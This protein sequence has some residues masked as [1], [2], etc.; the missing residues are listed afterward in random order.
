[1]EPI[2]TPETEV[3]FTRQFND[4]FEAARIPEKKLNKAITEIIG[5][6]CDFLGH[7]FHKKRIGSSGVGKRG[8]F[9]GI[10]YYRRVDGVLVFTFLYGKNEK[11]TLTSK[12]ENEL[13][14]VSEQFDKLTKQKLDILVEQNKLIKYHNKNIKRD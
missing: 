7:K 2:S 10:I 13:I 3:Y 14:L 11:E 9:R 5:G 1:M 12:E 4:K 6:L 8:G